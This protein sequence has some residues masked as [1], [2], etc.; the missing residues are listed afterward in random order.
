MKMNYAQL[1]EELY[2]NVFPEIFEN[3]SVV[4]WNENLVKAFPDAC[5]SKEFEQLI[6]G[7]NQWSKQPLAMAYAGHQFGHFNVLGDGRACLV[8]EWKSSE[9]FLHDV[10]LKGSGITPYSRR[11]D[12]RATLKA[13]LPNSNNTNACCFKYGRSDSSKRNGEGRTFSSHGF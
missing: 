10:H 3:A 9:G 1:P 5:K 12:G 6:N 13:M 7:N 11:G 4:F 2:A 8:D